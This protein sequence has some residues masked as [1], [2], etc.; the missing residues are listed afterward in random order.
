MLSEAD[1]TNPKCASQLSFLSILE[2][3]V[4]P[5]KLSID[6]QLNCH[7]FICL[8]MEGQDPCSPCIV[9]IDIEM[10]NFERPKSDDKT[11]GRI[12]SEGLPTVSELVFKSFHIPNKFNNKSLHIE[13][14]N[15]V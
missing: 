10:E 5:K 11:N 1:K 2:L 9:G 3:R 7:N 4:S 8:Q 6:S 15:G 12:K 14:E 13:S